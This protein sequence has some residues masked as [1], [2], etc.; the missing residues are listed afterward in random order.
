MAYPSAPWHLNGFA[1]LSLH[2][3]DVEQVQSFIPDGLSIV[4]VFPGK[5]LGCLYFSAYTQDSVLEY[6][7]LI[8]APALLNHGGKVG[9]WISHIYVDNEDSVA[10]GREIWGLPKEMAEFS[11]AN[12][13][14][15]VCQGNQELCS[16]SCQ[17]TWW[18][19]P[20]GFTPPLSG[21][22]FTRINSV[23][24][25]FEARL[26]GQLTVVRGQ[27]TL[28]EEGPFRSLGLSRPWFA[29]SAENLKLVVQGPVQPDA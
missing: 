4:S 12:S 24:T 1:L 26:K 8:V 7:E 20:Q 17:P 9:S 15:S 29:L 3:V 28:P 14:I 19:L 21:L 18:K 5:T 6:N 2:W 22:V 13:A 27:L 23:L 10:G 25:W 11:W 16:F